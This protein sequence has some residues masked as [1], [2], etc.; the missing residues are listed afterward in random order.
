MTRDAVTLWPTGEDRTVRERL[1]DSAIEAF[2][3]RGFGLSTTREIADGA[4]LS[5]AGM[6]SHFASKMDLLQE[7]VVLVH[8]Q[9]LHVIEDARMA[10][11]GGPAI[12]Q[13]RSVAHAYMLWQAANRQRASVISLQMRYLDPERFALVLPARNSIERTINDA[14]E[15]VIHEVE[16]T[17]E[18]RMVGQAI[19]SLGRDIPLWYRED[20]ET[21]TPEQ[22]ATTYTGYALRLAG[23]DETT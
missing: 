7:L 3:R 18:P 15:K 6:Y 5:S 4:G 12:E 8:D 13:L 16:H 23:V 2:S 20:R 22:L 10:S 14:A 1:L 11:E 9:V 17:A 21:M 19:I